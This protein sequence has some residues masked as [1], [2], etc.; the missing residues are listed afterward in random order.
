MIQGYSILKIALLR[1]AVLALVMGLPTTTTAAPVEPVWSLV[2]QEKPALVQTLQQLVNVESGSRDK[3]GLDRLSALIGQRLA[4]LGARVE[5]HEPSSAEIFRLYD[6]P[7]APGKIVIGRFQGK[8][9]RNIMLMAHMDTVYP[10]GTLATRPFRINGSRAYGPGIADDK[11]GIAAILHAV[12]I[13]QAMDFREFG[14]LT[15]VINGDEEISSPASRALIQRLAAEQDVVLSCEPPLSKQDEITLATSGIGLATLMV[16]GKAAHAGVNPELGRNAII[17]LAHRILQANDLSDPEQRITFNWT[18]MN[19][20]QVRNMIPDK[21]TAWADVRVNRLADLKLIEQ[22]Y[23]ERLATQTSLVPDTTAET[24][25]EQRRPP[26]EVTDASRVLGRKAQVIYSEIGRA[27]KVDESGAGGGTDA[28]FAA[29]SGSL[30]VAESF[31]LIGFG[32]HSSDEEY[33][34]LDSIEPRLYLLVRLI[35][36]SSRAS[37]D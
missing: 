2:Q 1:I 27:L 37:K 15:V 33:V 24:G 25:F 34:D 16:K 9:S 35:M 17:E 30:A 21:A 5:Y 10:H 7:D 3:E 6:T 22:R 26:L 8:G 14:T 20:G 4:A 19:G 28:A 32:F 18:L 12:S 23:H 29:V 13:L 31:G 11:G 36:E